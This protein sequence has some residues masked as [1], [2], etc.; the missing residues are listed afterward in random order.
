LGGIILF[1][2]EQKIT[3]LDLYQLYY[4][5]QDKD[6]K[7]FKNVQYSENA[8][9][10]SYKKYFETLQNIHNSEI[11]PKKDLN[12][13]EKF[14]KFSE[15]VIGEDKLIKKSLYMLMSFEEYAATWGLTAAEAHKLF[16]FDDFGRMIWKYEGLK[17]YFSKKTLF[18]LNFI[19]FD[20]KES[21][22]VGQIKTSLKKIN[23]D[24]KD[25]TDFIFE[26][27]DTLNKFFNKQLNDTKLTELY[28]NKDNIFLAKKLQKLSEK[29]EDNGKIIK[30]FN[31]FYELFVFENCYQNTIGYPQG[32]CADTSW[33]EGRIPTPSIGVPE[34]QPKKYIKVNKN[35]D[36]IKELYSGNFE[37]V[38]NAIKNGANVNAKNNL[39]FRPIELYLSNGVTENNGLII[40]PALFYYLVK[41]G[42]QFDQSYLDEFKN[43]IQTIKTA[44]GGRSLFDFASGTDT[45]AVAQIKEI[46]KN[47]QDVKDGN[48]TIE[49]I[50]EEDID[51]TISNQNLNLIQIGLKIG[52]YFAYGMT[53]R[54]INSLLEPM[55]CTILQLVSLSDAPT[56]VQALINAGA[57]INITSPGNNDWEAIHFAGW[58]GSKEVMKT[59]LDNGADINKRVIGSEKGNPDALN[60]AV[61]N[62]QFP[63]VKYLIELGASV[64]KKY[65]DNDNNIL[66]F[67]VE[68]K[69]IEMVQ[70]L[71][72]KGAD[73]NYVNPKGHRIIDFAKGY[74]MKK[75]L[76]SIMQ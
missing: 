23:P 41:K 6:V 74:Q 14:L 63:Q 11:S 49:Q 16:Y 72:S 62:N 32:V 64:D 37:K 67:A 19:D 5:V 51:N 54:D 70:Y 20:N 55:K 34:N 76:K 21:F 58:N 38:A 65:F 8:S 52:H 18:D 39:G 53:K 42:S 48:K 31:S 44:E 25:V 26:N 61:S 1:D 22:S 33:S 60:I 47:L 12:F 10:S 50:I 73:V 46:V 2:K 7:N 24:K 30:P 56:L 9:F 13:N 43:H 69:N 15:D 27:L 4:K 36:L 57:D 66:S 40:E 75:Y 35:S 45:P 28:N 59:L 68:T 17:D 29:Q 3:P 71:I